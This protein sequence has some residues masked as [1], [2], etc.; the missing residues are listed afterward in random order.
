M[1]WAPLTRRSWLRAGGASALALGLGP[2]R[3]SAASKPKRIIFC[4]QM[5]GFVHPN[6]RLIPPG[7]AAGG[8]YE[9]DLDPAG[10]SPIL[11]PLAP[12]TDRLLVLDGLSL[13]SAIADYWVARNPHVVAHIHLLTGAPSAVYALDGAASIASVDQQ[14]AAAIMAGPDAP[15]FASVELGFGPQGGVT[16]GAYNWS[17]PSTSLPYLYEPSTLF[18]LLF[19]DLGRPTS[20]GPGAW[21]E[22]IA[23][24]A[25]DEHAAVL[26]S[27]TGASADRLAAHRDLLAALAERFAGLDATV[28]TPPARPRAASGY[29]DRHAAYADVLA[30]AFA[31]DLTRVATIAFDNQ[32]AID[33]GGAPGTDL[34]AD[35]AHS[36]TEDNPMGS[37]VADAVMTAASVN[38]A[39]HV[40]TLLAALAAVKQD[41]GSTLLD[42]TLVVWTS[43]LA[44]GRHQGA[45]A[46]ADLP[47]ILAGG[48][49]F[50]TGRYVSY[51]QDRAVPVGAAPIGPDAVGPSHN[52]LL[53][54]LCRA[55][56]Q[57]DITSFGVE[58][59]PLQD[60]T[61]LDCT[62]PLGGLV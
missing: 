22:R 57:L 37:E 3:A 42:H 25:S 19:S 45:R 50:R 10:L 7:A 35:Y 39:G 27:K 59:L 30:A 14:I 24:F 48:D 6:L 28:C 47:V 33:C 56:G 26:A 17:G 16:L 49:A 46:Y 12:W 13:N 36:T 58:S 15:P 1:A 11:Q 18:D 51:A 52:H 9:F 34:H 62:G 60:G 40:S 5:H 31:C 20:S 41:D 21:R 55:M 2:Q 32:D 29:A 43:E 23:R 61:D 44:R 4:V 54:S 53:V 38:H 8:A